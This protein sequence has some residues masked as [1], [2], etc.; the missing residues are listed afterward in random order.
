MYREENNTPQDHRT[1]FS[2][3]IINFKYK[4]SDNRTFKKC[5]PFLKCAYTVYVLRFQHKI[6]V[7]LCISPRKFTNTI[8]K[9]EWDWKWHREGEDKPRKHSYSA[10]DQQ[11][12]PTVCFIT[13]PQPN[14][15]Y[16]KE[17]Q[18]A[19]INI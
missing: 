4:F 3:F 17:P 7:L 10:T 5:L 19:Q 14:P 11:T 16:C 12:P 18:Q 9:A 2:A 6:H 8:L 13:P 1:R 15:Y